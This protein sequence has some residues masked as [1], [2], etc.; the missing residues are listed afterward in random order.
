MLY[1]LACAQARSGNVRMALDSLRKAVEGGFSV[2]ALILRDTGLAAIRDRSEFRE[3][4]A[5][6]R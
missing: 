1:N 2:R 3:I 4:L 5:D 6:I